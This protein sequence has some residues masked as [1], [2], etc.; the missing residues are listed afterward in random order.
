M[1]PGF[2]VELSKGQFSD[3]VYP[4]KL[5]DHINDIIIS[6]VAKSLFSRRHSKHFRKFLGMTK[7]QIDLTNHMISEIHFVKVRWQIRTNLN[8]MRQM[9]SALH[10]LHSRNPPI[11]L[12]R[13][14]PDTVF[15]K[16]SRPERVPVCKMTLQDYQK[17]KQLDRRTRRFIMTHEGLKLRDK[18]IYF[19]APEVFR[20]P[21]MLSH[22][23]EA[24]I[25]SLGLNFV[26][27]L[28]R[29][30]FSFVIYGGRMSRY[31]YKHV[32]IY[33]LIIQ[34]IKNSITLYILTANIYHS[35]KESILFSN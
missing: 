6:A 5:P 7:G 11:I 18:L 16:W 26:L 21:T 32:N 8:I 13:V 24:D 4:P 12:G 33:L 27:L 15:I 14:D 31:A 20:D 28:A 23:V 3:F 2:N 30:I 22:T 1:E 25:F 19:L 29:R 17:R 9:S 10:F 35:P 34:I